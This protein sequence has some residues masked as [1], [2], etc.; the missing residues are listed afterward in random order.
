MFRKYIASSLLTK[1]LC[2]RNV[3]AGW[4]EWLHGPDLARGP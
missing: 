4:M 1:S 2:G 3:F